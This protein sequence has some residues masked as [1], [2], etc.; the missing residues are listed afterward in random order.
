LQP[1]P[2]WVL[3][4]R[5]LVGEATPE[6]SNLAVELLMQ[7]KQNLGTCFD[8]KQVDRRAFDTRVQVTP[9]RNAMPQPFGSVVPVGR[10]A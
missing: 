3:H 4:L 5:D 9:A 8:F 7:A 2:F 10:Q 6:L 1:D